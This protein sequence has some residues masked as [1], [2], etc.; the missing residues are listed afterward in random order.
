MFNWPKAGAMPDVSG[1]TKGWYDIGGAVA[2]GATQALGAA[3]RGVSKTIEAYSSPETSPDPSRAPSPEQQRPTT[4]LSAEE[5]VEA[6]LKSEADA[7]KAAKQAAKRDADAGDDTTKRKKAGK[8]AEEKAA[9][10][11]KWQAEQNALRKK[12]EATKGKQGGKLDLGTE[13]EESCR[14]GY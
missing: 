3:A 14:H 11:A 6:R 5:R 7:K 13:I 2:T 9:E 12:A 10:K 8:S 1:V 4:E